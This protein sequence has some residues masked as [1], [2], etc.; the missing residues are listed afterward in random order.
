V[1]VAAK[2]GETRVAAVGQFHFQQVEQ[3]GLAWNSLGM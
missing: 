3:L 2:P 1:Q